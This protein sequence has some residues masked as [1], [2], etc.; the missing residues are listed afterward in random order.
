MRVYVGNMGIIV[1][2]GRNVEE[3]GNNIFTGKSGIKKLTNYDYSDAPVRIGGEVLNEWLKS[4]SD[5]MDERSWA[6]LEIAAE[7]AVTPL[8]DKF[9][10]F[11]AD[12]I[13]VFSGT[14]Y[15]GSE[16]ILENYKLYL[17]KQTYK[18]SPMTMIK[19]MRYYSSSNLARKYKTEGPL[20]T[21]D[22]AC[23]SSL[24]ALGNAYKMVHS[25]VLDIAIVAGV[26]TPLTLTS[27]ICWD[28]LRILA[29]NES[30]PEKAAMPFDQNSSGIVL[31]EGAGVIVLA[32]EK[33]IDAM[34]VKPLAEVAGYG[35]SNDPTH[36]TKSNPDYMVKS[37]QKAFS[38]HP[39]YKDSV[40]YIQAH[41]T[42]TR[43]NDMEESRAIRTFFGD[44]TKNIKVNSIKSIVGHLI[45][46]SGITSAI[47][48]VIQMKEN[49]LHPTLNLNS[50][51]SEFNINYVGSKSESWNISSAIINAFA[52]G[53]SFA[54]VLVRRI[55]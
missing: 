14:S 40:N 38:D 41:G 32:S 36:I 18:I 30:S 13:G 46:G 22:T 47:A 25:G 26:D 49:K 6:L 28:R 9:P 5:S 24:H 54:S 11:E 10:L 15:T 20:L 37:M 7:E 34:K 19:A 16:I 42:G 43:V 53:G 4:G 51:Y 31:G 21:Y 17:N 27:I 50:P 23:S 52:F 45:G 2:N 8:H 48:T 12:R 29:N 39:E 3:F 55:D 35:Y 44:L 1:S 33:A